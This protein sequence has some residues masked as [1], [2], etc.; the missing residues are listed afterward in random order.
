[1]K[2]QVWYFVKQPNRTE[3]ARKI[4]IY[5]EQNPEAQDTIEGILNWWILERTVHY[6]K[7]RVEEVIEELVSRNLIVARQIVGL[8]IMYS[9]NPSK[10]EE[11]R[12]TYRESNKNKSK[13]AQKS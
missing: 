6:E 2:L 5:L 11:I 4:L 7:I 9:L 10:L 1:M 13:K 8:P 12:L 3:I